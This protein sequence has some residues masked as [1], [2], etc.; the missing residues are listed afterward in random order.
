[1]RKS[2]VKKFLKTDPFASGRTEAADRY[3][4][5]VKSAARWRLM[6]LILL[7]SCAAIVFSVIRMA[8][9]ATDVPFIIQVDQHTKYIAVEPVKPVKIDQVASAAVSRYIWSLRT[10]LNDQK[11]QEGLNS[12]VTNYTG[13]NTEAESKNKGRNRTGSRRSLFTSRKIVH[14]TVNSV[15]LQSPNTWFA[16]WTEDEFLDGRRISSKKYNGTFNMVINLPK[17]SD[18]VDSFRVFITDYEISEEVEGVK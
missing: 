18:D 6:S 16:K 13:A 5:L 12:F 4:H 17:S 8:D 1:M 7:L 11:I 3:E 9:S 15:Q 2:E 14:T 10:V